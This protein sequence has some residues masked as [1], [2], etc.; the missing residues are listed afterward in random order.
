MPDVETHRLLAQLARA[1]ADVAATEAALREHR[2]RRQVACV[3]GTSH[4][5]GDLAVIITHWYTQ[6]QGCMEGDYWSEGEWH[7][8]CP[9][10]GQ[11][12]RILFDDASV[13]WRDRNTFG[14]A[15][16]PSFKRLYRGLFASQTDEHLHDGPGGAN[17]YDIDQRR[18]EFELPA[19]PARKS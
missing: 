10:T 13:D 15:G 7:F 3:C 1:Q 18:D 9:T 17:N 5:I 2:R 6:P 8:V 19:K 4:A 11:R 16:A 14:I 12:N